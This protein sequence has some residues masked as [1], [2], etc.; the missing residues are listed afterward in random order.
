MNPSA[1]RRRAHKWRDHDDFVVP[2]TDRH[3]HAVVL[4]ALIFPQQRIRFWI[5]EIRVWIEHVQHAGNRAVVNRFV[6]IYWL[7][8]IL[9]YDVINLR[10]LLQ[11]LADIGVA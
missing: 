11:A 10:E 8:I 2:R 1:I 9:L 3:S 7:G 4:S 6:R 5:E